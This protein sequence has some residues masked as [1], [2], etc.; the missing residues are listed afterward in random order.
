ME[1]GHIVEQGSP[2]ELENSTNER[3]NQFVKKH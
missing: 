1:G 2:A 3:F